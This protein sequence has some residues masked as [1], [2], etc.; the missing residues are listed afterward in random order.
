MILIPIIII[1][2]IG[3]CVFFI[4]RQNKTLNIFEVIPLSFG[5]GLSIVVCELVF[6]GI[7]LEHISF[8]PVLLSFLV[9]SIVFTIS[10]VVY[11]NYFI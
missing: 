3:L 7:S 6:Q 8:T 2:I 1:Y 9:F 10:T 4:T 11:S 5:I